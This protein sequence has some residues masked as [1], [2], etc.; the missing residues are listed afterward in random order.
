LNVSRAVADHLQVGQQQPKHT[1]FSFIP[2]SPHFSEKYQNLMTIAAHLSRWQ[3]AF[4]Q[5]LSPMT[6]RVPNND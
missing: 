4:E 2:I 6:A 3:Q 1:G 5:V